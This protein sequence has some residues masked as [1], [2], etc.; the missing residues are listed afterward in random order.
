MA[1]KELH[2]KDEQGCIASEL[3]AYI[4]LMRQVWVLRPIAWLIGLSSIR[5]LLS[6]LYHRMVER[7]LQRSGRL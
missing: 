4:L 3:D 1:L 7:R 6:K 2:V 5:P